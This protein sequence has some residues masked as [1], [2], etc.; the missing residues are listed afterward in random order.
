MV[1][2]YT[3][4]IPSVPNSTAVLTTGALDHLLLQLSDLVSA[5]HPPE[6]YS[7]LEAEVFRST[8]GGHVRHLLD[9]VRALLRGLSGETTDEASQRM[10][11]YD[12]RAR[13]TA[14]EHDPDACLALIA[15]LRHELARLLQKEEPVFQ[16]SPPQVPLYVEQIV[17]PGHPAVILESNAL[18]E[19]VFVYH[20]SIHHAA[21]IAARLR[22]AGMSVPADFGVAPATLAANL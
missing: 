21:L 20:H 7:H 1:S 9:H 4:M 12:R 2:L 22:Q 10:I 3:G 14:I 17:R 18:R 8:P 5:I 15:E 6:L 19:L 11:C 13:G 16:Q